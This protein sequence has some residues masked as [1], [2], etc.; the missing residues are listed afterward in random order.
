[1]IPG[2]AAGQVLTTLEFSFSNPGARSMGLG[3]AFVALADDATAAFANPAGLVQLVQPEI[4]IEGRSWSYSTPYTQGGRAAGDPTGLGIDTVA[5]PLEGRSSVDLTGISYVSFVYPRKRWSVAVFQHQLTNFEMNQEIQG[6]FAPGTVHANSYR[7]PI[8]RGFFDLDVVAHG[9]SMGARV[10]ETL[11]L[12]LGI[13][14][15]GPS[16]TLRGFEYLPDEDTAESYFSESSFRSDRLVDVVT[17]RDTD[18]DWGL[19]AGFL[20]RVSDRWQIG[21]AYREGPEL[22]MVFVAE[23]GPAHET[24]PAGGVVGSAT[25]P[26]VFPDV[27]GLGIAYRSSNELWTASF[28]WARVEYSTIYDSL[29]PPVNSPESSI[30]DGDELH[31]GGEYVFLDSMPVVALRAGLWSDPDHQTKSDSRSPFIQAE[32]IPGSDELHYGIGLGVAYPAFQIDLGI[33]LS[34]LR[35]TAS[36]SAIF[37]F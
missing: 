26:W 30:D 17:A 4:S 21:G 16:V 35:D 37:S 27:Y 12:G 25:T 5:G 8:E 18:S 9:V 7:G 32:L 28:E 10:S 11:T 33:D 19:A 34:E 3:G 6:L 24:V 36:L 23:A 2:A 20:W 22:E 29:D 15:F 31:L 1:M 13:S 14:R